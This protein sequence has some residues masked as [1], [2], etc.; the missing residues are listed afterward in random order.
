MKLLCE[1]IVNTDMYAGCIDL[2]TGYDDFQTD[3]SFDSEWHTYRVANQIVPS[4]TQIL[5]D[6][7]YDSPNIDKEVL[8]YAQDK[9]T[10]VHKEIQE[11]L[12]EGKEGITEELYEFIRLFNENKEL[13]EEKAIFDFKTYAVAT[14]KNRKKCYEQT[15]MYAD[16]VGYLTDDRPWKLYLVHLPHGKQGRIYDLVKEFEEVNNGI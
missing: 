14:P 3:V 13:F 12:E 6:G 1:K 15:A 4:V 2:L 11:W 16:A 7:A 10:L 5:D 8:K 9:G